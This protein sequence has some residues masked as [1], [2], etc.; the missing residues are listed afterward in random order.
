MRK[1]KL[2]DRTA[3]SWR[4]AISSP[5]STV[6]VDRDDVSDS[7]GNSGGTI[8]TDVPCVVA[9]SEAALSSHADKQFSVW[10]NAGVLTGEDRDSFMYIMKG[11]R[12]SF[13]DEDLDIN[14]AH[15]INFDHIS[16]TYFQ[17]I[18]ETLVQNNSGD[19]FL[20]EKSYKPFISGQPFV[21]WGQQF[22]AKA[23]REQGYNMFDAW[24]NHH[25]DSIADPTDRMAELVLEIERLYA[26]T[27]Q[28]WSLMLLEMLPKIEENF[29]FFLRAKE[30]QY[31]LDPNDINK[32]NVRLGTKRYSPPPI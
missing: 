17:I 2:L 9:D 12:R 28:E 31:T 4:G 3:W 7:N 1:N 23:L 18:N 30:R 29:N 19:P 10:L 21:I 14:K 22:T 11:P 24:I 8:D 5:S 13:P 16:S 20:S 26:M 27:P 15:S 25:Y 6:T 32:H